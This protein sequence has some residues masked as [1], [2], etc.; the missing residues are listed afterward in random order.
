MSAIARY[1]HQRRSGRVWLIGDRRVSNATVAS[2]ERGAF[3]REIAV[4]GNPV[5]VITDQGKQ[6]IAD[7]GKAV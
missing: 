4:N 2:L 3:L 6:V 7:G 5:L 1:R